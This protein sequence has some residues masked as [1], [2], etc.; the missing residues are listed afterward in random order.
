MAVT[1]EPFA[2]PDALAPA[3]QRAWVDLQNAGWAEWSPKHERWSL[4]AALARARVHVPPTAVHHHLAR[5]A[6]D[7]LVGWGQV[8]WR[9]GEPE[10]EYTVEELRAAEAAIAAGEQDWWAVGVRHDASGRLVGLSEMFLPVPVLVPAPGRLTG[11]WV[12]RAGPAG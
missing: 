12:R 9:E 3:D 6:T 7:H 5:D 10:S 4:D 11:R 1:I 2:H 8:T